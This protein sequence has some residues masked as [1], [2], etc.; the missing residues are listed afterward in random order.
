MA[1]ALL[2]E[3]KREKAVEVLDRCLEVM[4]TDVIPANY[5]MLGFVEVYY[6]AGEYE[7]A[8]AIINEIF[9]ATEQDLK[10][11][12]ALDKKQRKSKDRDIQIGLYTFQNVYQQAKQY[13]QTDV[14]D[15]L[16][17]PLLQTYASQYESLR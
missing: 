2:A 1:E 14:S 6:K 8:R 17:M 7:K 3:G 9:E 11:Y 16:A 13:G 12:L 10:Y 15:S 4:P 5:F